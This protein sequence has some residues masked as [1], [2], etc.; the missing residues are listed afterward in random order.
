MRQ[1]WATIALVCCSLTT[2]CLPGAHGALE[3]ATFDAR[4]LAIWSAPTDDWHY[5]AEGQMLPPAWPTF[6]VVLEEEAEHLG[7]LGNT[8]LAFVSAPAL[9]ADDPPSHL[10]AHVRYVT[11]CAGSD[12]G[13]G[14]QMLKRRAPPF[15]ASRMQRWVRPSTRSRC[16]MCSHCIAC[17]RPTWL[18]TRWDTL[19][20]APSGRMT[21]KE[22][23]VELCT[24]RPSTIR[25]GRSRWQ[26]SGMQQS[27]PVREGGG[28]IWP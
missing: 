19:L 26:R 6:A 27:G 3:G 24:T 18:C 5:G 17:R 4:T 20:V 22:R 8:V 10:L 2:G 25:S 23:R 9:R 1:G 13:M 7:G 11:P 15:W 12:F 28:T 16:A 14:I 21:R